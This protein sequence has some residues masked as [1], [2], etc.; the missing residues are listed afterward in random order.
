MTILT[1]HLHSTTSLTKPL[2]LSQRLSNSHSLAQKISRHLL[3][4]YPFALPFP[5]TYCPGSYCGLTARRPYCRLTAHR[6]LTACTQDRYSGSFASYWSG[7]GNP[8]SHRGFLTWVHQGLCSRRSPLQP[9]PWGG[10]G[11]PSTTSRRPSL[12]DPRLR[13]VEGPLTRIPQW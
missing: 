1:L 2:R 10:R 8:G 5:R 13:L 4:D 3:D 7:F 12:G 6:G 11:G 9:P